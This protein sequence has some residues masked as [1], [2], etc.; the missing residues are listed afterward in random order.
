MHSK[1]ELLKEYREIIKICETYHLDEYLEQLYVK[2]QDL[3]EPLKFMI[4]GEGKSGKS[5]LL[6][7]ISRFR[8]L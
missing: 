7:V 5:T 6:N 1:E 3:E 8:Y 4:V 2:L